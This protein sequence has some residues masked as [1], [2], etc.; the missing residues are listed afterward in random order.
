MTS[1][2]AKTAKEQIA[3]I[4]ESGDRDDES[5]AK[6]LNLIW[7]HREDLIAWAGGA[8]KIEPMDPDK[9]Y[10]VV[11]KAREL[12]AW[13]LDSTERDDDTLL[14]DY[15]WSLREDLIAWARDSKAEDA[16]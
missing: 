2:K 11:M 4:L 9:S 1:S 14:L 10:M 16:R 15:V 3:D 12:I 5:D 6:L 13:I 7:Y 8:P